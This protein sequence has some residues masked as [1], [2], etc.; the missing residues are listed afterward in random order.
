MSEHHEVH[1]RFSVKKT[2]SAA[3][4]RLESHIYFKVLSNNPTAYERHQRQVL[5]EIIE[6]AAAS[7]GEVIMQ[8]VDG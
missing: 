1:V 7:G 6:A 8:Q 4:E 5:Y 3:R 2:P